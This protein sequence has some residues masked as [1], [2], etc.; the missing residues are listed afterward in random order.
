EVHVENEWAL[1]YTLLES[2]TLSTKKLKKDKP[3]KGCGGMSDVLLCM[4]ALLRLCIHNNTVQRK[5]PN[6]S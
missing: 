2:L 5:R 4:H 1:V 3:G 6:K